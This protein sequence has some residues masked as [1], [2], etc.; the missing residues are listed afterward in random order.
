MLIRLEVEE[1]LQHLH[2]PILRRIATLKLESYTNVQIAELL[3]LN[4]RTIERKLVAI[5][6]RFLEYEAGW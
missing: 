1:F 3:K 4:E 6:R 2:D 5:R